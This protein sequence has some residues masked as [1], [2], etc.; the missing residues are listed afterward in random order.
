MT[1]NIPDIPI[2]T[3]GIVLGAALLLIGYVKEKGWF[4]FS[5]PQLPDWDFFEEEEDDPFL[6]FESIRGAQ[7]KSITPVGLSSCSP[8]SI[9]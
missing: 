8:P 9:I 5:R 1:F 2:E 7:T 3:I 4:N 6:L